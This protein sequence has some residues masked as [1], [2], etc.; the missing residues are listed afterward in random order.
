[1]LDA[2]AL[3]NHYMPKLIIY[4]NLGMLHSR[5]QPFGS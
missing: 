5:A 4:Q 2:P 1:V 3:G